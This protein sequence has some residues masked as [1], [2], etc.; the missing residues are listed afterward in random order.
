MEIWHKIPSIS[1]NKVHLLK[2]EIGGRCIRHRMWFQATKDRL[3]RELQG[4]ENV[5][6]SLYKFHRCNETSP[7]RNIFYPG[8]YPLENII[9]FL[10]VSCCNERTST[11]RSIQVEGILFLEVKNLFL[12]YVEENFFLMDFSCK[13]I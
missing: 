2:V 7:G 3:Y 8:F 1:L 10:T 5:F 12:C 6:D 4:V 9:P 13:F 11:F